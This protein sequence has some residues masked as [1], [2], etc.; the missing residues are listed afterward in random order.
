MVLARV[1]Y[2][3]TLRKPY[4]SPTYQLHVKHTLNHLVPLT[5]PLIQRVFGLRNWNSH[6]YS[7][8]SPYGSATQPQSLHSRAYWPEP[9]IPRGFRD[10]FRRTESQEDINGGLGKQR[11]DR[12]EPRFITS[13]IEMEE[14]RDNRISVP[15]S[16]ASWRSTEESIRQTV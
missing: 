13:A 12:E 6:T 10:I 7:A 8:D 4:E 15:E 11:E 16:A 2:S 1:I 3:H 5:Y 14:T 9:H